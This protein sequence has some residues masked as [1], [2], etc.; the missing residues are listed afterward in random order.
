MSTKT[1]ERTNV[2]VTGGAGSIGS[3]LCEFLLRE[4]K[5]NVI[6]VDNYFSGVEANIDRL[7]SHPRFEFI[8]HDITEPLDFTQFPSTERFKTAFVGV[9]EIYH[10]AGPDSPRVYFASPVEVLTLASRGTKNML[11]LALSY[12]A[13]FLLASDTSV[14]GER[15][16][17]TPVPEE[18][19][20]P[21]DFLSPLNV[22]AQSKRMAE[23][24]VA[25]Y[26]R[27]YSLE[28]KIVRLHNVYGLNMHFGDGRFIPD[29]IEKA[30]NNEPIALS[31]RMVTS[32]FLFA[33]DAVDALE[34]I[35]MTDKNMIVNLAQS[36]M[37]TFDEIIKTILEHTGST[38]TVTRAEPPEEHAA[39][40]SIWE[41][42]CRAIDTGRIRGDM[43][44]FPVVLLADGLR[45]TIDFMKSTRR[46]ADLRSVSR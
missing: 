35:M 8:R 42:Y 21:L 43:G 29:T 9:K 32:S 36:S 3:Q 33:S 14:Y 27:I 30:L 13:K 17:H 15:E 10:L 16:E 45:K 5:Y 18:Y 20:G 25:T 23:T 26:Q 38:S 12:R 2:L 39:L 44:W 11:D 24:L 4:E 22:V 34:K 1:T 37:Y 7:L 6:C 41:R 31:P 19:A 28:T 40:T 46:L